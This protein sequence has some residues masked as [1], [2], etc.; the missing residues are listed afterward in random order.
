MEFKVNC[1]LIHL[2]VAISRR[3][4]TFVRE[5]THIINIVM[6]TQSK[7]IVTYKMRLVPRDDVPYMWLQHE[8]KLCINVTEYLSNEPHYART[9]CATL[10]N[11]TCSIDMFP[12]YQNR[13]IIK[14]CWS[15][16]AL[17]IKRFR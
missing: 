15:Q 3:N 11:S 7:N 4:Y 2:A 12:V 16:L 14:G 9:G 1:I 10:Q 13:R 5:K 6:Y 17:Y 8:C